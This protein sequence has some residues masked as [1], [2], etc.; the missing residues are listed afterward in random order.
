M[1]DSFSATSSYIH[2]RSAIHLFLRK[3]LKPL[4]ANK[5]PELLT[6]ID[7]AINGELVTVIMNSPTNF[8][9]ELS[10]QDRNRGNDWINIAFEIDGVSDARLVEDNKLPFVDMSEGITIVFENGICGL[11]VGNYSSIEALKD[12]ALYLIGSSVKYE[13]RPFG[14]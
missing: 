6:R 11:A 5:T 2:S 8:A 14:S 9:I 12:A 7:H 13:E 4:H 10:V 3:R 1:A